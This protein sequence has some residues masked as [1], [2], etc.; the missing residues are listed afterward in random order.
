MNDELFRKPTNHHKWM[1]PLK[2]RFQ[3]SH[4]GQKLPNSQGKTDVPYSDRTRR[5]SKITE[6]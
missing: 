5:R 1:Q 4:L 2:Y 6:D 3:V